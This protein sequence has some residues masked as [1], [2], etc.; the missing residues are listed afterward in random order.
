MTHRSV[1]QGTPGSLRLRHWNKA[2]YLPKLWNPHETQ[3]YAEDIVKRSTEL[4]STDFENPLA[5]AI[6][7]S[8]LAGEKFAQLSSNMECEKCGLGGVGCNLGCCLSDPGDVQ[9]LVRR[10]AA[11]LQLG[12]VPE[13]VE[14]QVVHTA[15][16]HLIVHLTPVGRLVSIKDEADEGDAVVRDDIELM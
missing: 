1:D 4:G 12:L 16:R 11:A 10:E 8:S 3:A 9:L 2:R 6:R 7:A 15:P 13:S 5:D 14:L